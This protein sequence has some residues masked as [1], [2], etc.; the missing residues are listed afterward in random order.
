MLSKIILLLLLL[1]LTVYS[2]YTA[3]KKAGTAAQYAKIQLIGAPYGPSRVRAFDDIRFLSVIFVVGTHVIENGNSFSERSAGWI[4]LSLLSIIF[5]NCNVLFVMLSGALI[6]NQKEESLS[7]FYIRR[8][9]KVIIPMAAY[10]MFYLYFGLYHSGLTDPATLFDAVRRMLSGPSDWNPHFWLIYVIISFYIAAPFF[11]IMVQNM[12]DK[13]LFSFVILSLGMNAALTFLPLLGINFSF[14]TILCSWE[15]VF[16]LGYFWTRDSSSRYRQP[17]VFLGIVSFFLT[18]LALYFFPS[19]GD[20][21]FSKAPSMLLMS[22]SVF[23]W[24]LCREKSLKV[25]GPLVRMIGKYGFSI[26]MIHWYLL[27]YAVEEGLG[28][29]AATF[30]VIGGAILTTAA[31]L[32]LSLLFAILFDNTVVI[33]METVFL[34]ICSLFYPEN[35]TNEKRREDQI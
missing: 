1:F 27:H 16:I 25:P 19:S 34:K 28:L 2:H 24:F 15:S 35:R 10:Y 20:Y 22:S 23:A 12:S 26:L 7:S 21:L 4:F 13:L 14:I 3:A 8:A 31:T 33:S 30:G 9:A 6:L 11:K 29:N 17:A 32:A 18:A 5:Y